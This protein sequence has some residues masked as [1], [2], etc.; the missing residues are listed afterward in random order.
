MNCGQWQQTFLVKEVDERIKCKKC[1]AKLLAIVSPANQEAQKLLKKSMRGALS[2]I[3]KKRLDKLIQTADLFLVYGSRA[4]KALAARGIGPE[5]AK[6]LLARFYK[7]EDEF[8]KAIL[9]A[10]RNY[11]RTKRYWKI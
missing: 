6:K 5:T 1:E 3:E 11:L 2:K 8:L 10:E 4:V 7:D 9:E